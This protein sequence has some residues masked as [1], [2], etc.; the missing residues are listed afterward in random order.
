MEAAKAQDWVAESQER[1]VVNQL[2]QCFEWKDL[3]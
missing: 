3:S 1:K 2:E